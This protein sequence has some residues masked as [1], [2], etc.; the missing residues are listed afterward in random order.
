MVQ[1]KRVLALSLAVS[2]SLSMLAGC[3]G[4]VTPSDS[5]GSSPS[6]AAT[7]VVTKQEEPVAISFTTPLYNEPPNFQSDYYK[8]LDKLA[9]VKLAI[10]AIPFNAYKEQLNLALSSNELTDVVVNL[11][12]FDPVTI[13]AVRQG[14]FHDLTPY[15]GDLKKYPNLAGIPK[16]IWDN[17]KIDG[18]VFAIPRP[19]GLT[20]QSLHIRKDWLDKLGLKAPS[21]VEELRDVL[22]AFVE[23]DPDGNGKNDTYGLA[24]FGATLN[25][26]SAP[27]G[28]AFGANKP[29]FEGDKLL[30]PWMTNG[31]RDML[32]YFRGLYADKI[33]TQEYSVQ[34]F[35][36]DTEMFQSGKAGVVGSSINGA[37]DIWT[38]TKKTDPKAEILTLPPLKGPGGDASFLPSG[39]LGGIMISSKVPKDKVEK[40]LKY[41]DQSA[42]KEFVD[43]EKYGIEGKHHTKENGLPKVNDEMYKKEIGNA[44]LMVGY[45]DPYNK[46]LHAKATPEFNEVQKKVSDQYAAKGVP[47][48]LEGLISDTN[49][50]RSAD[51]FKD[52]NTILTKVVVGQSTME[53]WDAYLNRLKADP[54]VQKILK[55]Y[56][57]QYKLK[58]GDKK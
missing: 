33:I 27:L 11:E 31:Y 6:P 48:P 21:T 58:F 24:V 35:G 2:L 34:K 43:F 28:S 15:L 51:L 7:G 22:K 20:D 18:K 29:T 57:D 46:A 36:Q 16:Q 32:E 9:N 55:E 52:R 42:S 49:A 12:L 50:K 45:Y 37:W 53:E 8:E 17:S 1:R 54:D 40:I 56:A 26:A 44:S 13:G 23:K 25:S 19:R 4:N 38:N 10:K 47:N 30:I 41:L 14:A 39:Y 3:G 5:K